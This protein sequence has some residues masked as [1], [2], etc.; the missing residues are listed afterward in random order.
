MRRRINLRRSVTPPVTPPVTPTEKPKPSADPERRL[1]RS[2]ATPSG[3]DRM[4]GRRS[5]R[6]ADEFKRGAAGPFGGNDYDDLNATNVGGGP[7]GKPVRFAEIV[8]GLSNTFLASETV[9]GQNND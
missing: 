1:H 4:E 6:R 7:Y 2:L 9:Q 8:D 5:W 3:G